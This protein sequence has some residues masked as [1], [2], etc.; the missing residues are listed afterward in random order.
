MTIDLHYSSKSKADEMTFTKELAMALGCRDR[1]MG[2]D[3]EERRITL[4]RFGGRKHLE[5]AYHSGW[6]ETE[7]YVSNVAK[8]ASSG[9]F[10][11]SRRHFDA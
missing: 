4:E 3:A 10:P 6:L 11:A 2:V 5:N 9:D 8:W 1:V 7:H